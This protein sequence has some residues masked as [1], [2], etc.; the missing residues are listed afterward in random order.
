MAGNKQGT[1]QM[2]RKLSPALAHVQRVNAEHSAVHA[3]QNTNKMEGYSEYERQLAQLG[4]HKRH[5]SK[6][7]SMEKKQLQKGEFL[8]D[9]DAYI[10]G[11]LASN[12]GAQDDVLLTLMIWHLD[13]KSIETAMSIAHYAIEH[14][15][16]MP[17][18]FS[19]NLP[20]A[21]TEDLA[22]LSLKDSDAV[23]LEQLQDC[24][25]LMQD[26]DML[27]EIR[28]KLHRAIAEQQIAGEHKQEALNHF[29]RALELNP[30]IG[31]K[32]Q[33]DA[34]AKQLEKP[35]E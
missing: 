33:R 14:D 5:L 21:F 9:Y 10:E 18:T 13:C 28:A 7:S 6:I 8:A 31:C 27:D 2:A 24:L 34:I 26:K 4:T 19:R 17:D 32:K 35:P 16:S 29:N 3:A 15:L 20:A 23:S 12:S 30:K 25:N 11:V 22:E 1:N